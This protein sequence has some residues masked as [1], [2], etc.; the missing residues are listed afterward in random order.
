MQLKKPLVFASALSISVAGI[1]F[2]QRAEG[3]RYTA[4]PDVGGVPTI[5]SGSTRA[6]RLGQT[7]TPGECEVRLAEDSTYAGKAIARLVTHVLTQQ[8]YDALVSLVFNIGPTAFQK[9]TL[10]RK[11][12]SGQCHAVGAEFLRWDRVK[13]KRIPGLSTRRAKESTLWLEDCDVWTE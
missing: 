11:L 13:G 4:Y 2:I 5:C 6:V 7:A 1:Q 12:N 10:L 3:V 9:S 8:Q